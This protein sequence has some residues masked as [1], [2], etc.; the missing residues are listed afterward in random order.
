MFNL[1]LRIAFISTSASGTATKTS[2][3]QW[4]VVTAQSRLH[5]VSPVHQNDEWNNGYPNYEQ[6]IVKYV[7]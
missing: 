4:S 7:C 1:N 5:H 3:G 6:F 2:N